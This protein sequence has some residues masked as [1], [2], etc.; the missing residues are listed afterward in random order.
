MKG[1]VEYSRKINVRNY[2]PACDLAGQGIAKISAECP[3][4]EGRIYEHMA[5]YWTIA[6][7]VERSFPISLVNDNDGRTRHFSTSRKRR[8]QMEDEL[9][10]FGFY[11]HKS[12]LFKQK[13]TLTRLLAPGERFWDWD[14][15]LRGSAK[16]LIDALASLK[17]FLNDSPRW[18]VGVSGLQ[19]DRYRKY[20]GG[21]RIKIEKA[22]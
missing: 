3:D 16:E 9:R 17:F 10:L 1:F 20:G 2:C 18:V 11:R 12:P 21:V 14:S 5:D 8:Q 13:V 19:D 7:T 4:C 22:E 15:V 6:E